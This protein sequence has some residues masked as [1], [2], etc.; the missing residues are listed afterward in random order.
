MSTSE[1]F[2]KVAVREGPGICSLLFGDRPWGGPLACGVVGLGVLRVG[3]PHAKLQPLGAEKAE[4]C[5]RRRIFP[6]EQVS[7]GSQNQALF[8]GLLLTSCGT[9]GHR[10]PLPLHR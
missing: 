1:S 8:S 2:L 4:L 6:A 9:R 7:A 10:P 3:R 5:L